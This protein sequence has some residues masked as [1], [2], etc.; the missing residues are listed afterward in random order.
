MFV[1]D[2]NNASVGYF[3]FLAL[4]PERPPFAFHPVV[5]SANADSTD[6]L[7][8]EVPPGPSFE[9]SSRYHD[10]NSIETL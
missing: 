7:I 8:S 6:R 5:P 3:A 9:I 4:L 10:Y 2:L 1:W